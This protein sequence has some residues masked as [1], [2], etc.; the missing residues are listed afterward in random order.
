MYPTILSFLGPCGVHM[1]DD[2]PPPPPILP[3]YIAEPLQ[4]QKVECLEAIIEYANEL[5]EHRQK[6][7]VIVTRRKKEDS[8]H[9]EHKEE[10]ESR[11]EEI[12]TDPEDYGAPKSAYITTKYPHGEAGYYYWQWR[13]GDSWHNEYIAP[14]N[15]KYNS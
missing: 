5:I 15:P 3:K 12:S 1:N 11:D 14:V 9:D 4:K 2:V 13:E 6:Q 10:L 8:D 7:D